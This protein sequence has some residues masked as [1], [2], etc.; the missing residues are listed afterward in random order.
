MLQYGFGSKNHTASPSDVA[1]MTR[2]C[3][4][5]TGKPVIACEYSR[6]GDSK[7]AKAAGRAAIAAG[8]VGV[9]NGF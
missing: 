6:Y 3:I 2:K 1:A 4:A 8:A 7:E 5:E 9:C